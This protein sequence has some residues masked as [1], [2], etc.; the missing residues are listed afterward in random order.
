MKEEER[1]KIAESIRI[2]L[3]ELLKKNDYETVF[4]TEI[5]KHAHVGRRTLYRY[6]PTKDDIMRYEADILM[7]DFAR[8]VLEMQSASLGTTMLAWFTFC[9]E[10]LESLTLLK[11]AHLLYFIEDNLPNLIMEVA[12][13]TK[14]RGM[15]IDLD[16]AIAA[17][18]IS[19]M[20]E[21]YFEL[22]GIWKLTVLWIDDPHK[23]S[24]E[25]M[26]QLIVKIWEQ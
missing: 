10:H 19:D 14:D 3:L 20:Y 17:A 24:P 4:M 13:K 7:D 18:P 23:K 16:A 12:L 2:A 15:D 5:A 22:A 9:A 11:K 21:F 26:S 1:N 8:K 25:E 6:F